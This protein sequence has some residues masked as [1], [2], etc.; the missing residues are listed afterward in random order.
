MRE[1]QARS[2]ASDSSSS[3][4][5]HNRRTPK[6]AATAT[7]AATTGGNCSSASRSFNFDP[8]ELSDSSG[9][10][11]SSNSSS[12]SLAGLAWAGSVQSGNISVPQIVSSPERSPEPQLT[13]A[14]ESVVHTGSSSKREP[15][16]AVSPIVLRSEQQQHQQQQQQQQQ[17]RA[18]DPHSQRSL[19]LQL[20]HS[21]RKRVTSG[22]QSA[23]SEATAQHQATQ[24]QQQQQRSP[25]EEGKAGGGGQQMSPPSHYSISPGAGGS[26]AAQTA[27]PTV[28]HTAANNSWDEMSDSDTSAFAFNALEDGTLGDYEQQETVAS[29]SSGGAAHALRRHDSMAF[30]TNSS[31][32]SE[33]LGG[34]ISGTE[35]SSDDSSVSLE[36]NSSRTRL[37]RW[38]TQA[39]ADNYGHC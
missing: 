6:R 25:S 10:V 27:A 31:S 36:G 19:T 33:D 34:G 17:E 12:A 7:T 9:S 21:L 18:V 1:Q 16:P 15:R 37:P 8:A 39:P 4:S 14:A 13:A 24:Q 22:R 3:S 28:A 38:I 5:S 2:Q 29:S 30:S 23:G 26:S 32:F 11:Y 20:L 35:G